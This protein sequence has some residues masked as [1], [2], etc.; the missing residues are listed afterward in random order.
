ML[1]CHSPLYTNANALWASPKRTGPSKRFKPS[2]VHR[3]SPTARQPRARFTN[4][5]RQDPSEPLGLRVLLSGVDP[6]SQRD[7]KDINGA[8]VL[9]VDPFSLAW[10]AKLRAGDLLESVTTEDG[11]TQTFPDGD[12][13]TNVLRAAHGR[14]TLCVRPRAWSAEDEA[15]SL[16]QAAWI[17]SRTRVAMRQA[18]EEEPVPVGRGPIR[19]PPRLSYGDDED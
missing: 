17:G 6:V 2:L 7:A 18:V 13:C 5:E 10:C 19:S 15:A 9:Y 16:L 1:P 14:L 11:F 4:I 3:A 12:A 8:V